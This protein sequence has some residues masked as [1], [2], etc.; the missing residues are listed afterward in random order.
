[1]NEQNY[2]S[3][4]LTWNAQTHSICVLCKCVWVWVLSYAWR[5]FFSE[6]FEVAAGWKKSTY[7]IISMMCA[8][9]CS[10]TKAKT[11]LLLLH[12]HSQ[13]SLK[14][15]KNKRMRVCGRELAKIKWVT[16]LTSFMERIMRLKTTDSRSHFLISSVMPNSKYCCQRTEYFVGWTERWRAVDSEWIPSYLI[17]GCDIH[18]IYIHGPYTGMLRNKMCAY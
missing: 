15:I 6:W 16:I 13:N 17:F 2:I 5:S 9:A 4:M 14:R 8:S 10:F 11:I 3:T 7:K 18:I 1:M 12:R